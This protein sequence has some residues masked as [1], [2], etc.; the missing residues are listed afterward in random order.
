MSDQTCRKVPPDRDPNDKETQSQSKKSKQEAVV[1]DLMG[2]EMVDASGEAEGQ[3]IGVNGE[4]QANTKEVGTLGSYKDSLLGFQS[5]GFNGAAYGSDFLDDEPLLSDLVDHEWKLPEPTEEIKN[6]MSIY[7]VVPVTEEE[8]N[9]DCR[10]WN[11]SLIITVLGARFNVY[12]LK[13]RLGRLWG[14]QDFNLIDL[15]NN[16]FVVHWG[17][18]EDWG[19]KYKR[20]LFEDP[21]VVGHH[22]VLVQRWSPYF[23]PFNN[24]LGRI[25][26]WV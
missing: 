2:E 6:L 20:V 1:D 3:T 5:Q 17:S 18:N 22:S 9:E 8:F 23:D 21:W 13:E 24:P 12:R 10:Q 25:A 4:G 26:T 16:Y 15:P 14:F 19:H 7:L 11:N